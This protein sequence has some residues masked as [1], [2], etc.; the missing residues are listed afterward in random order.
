[1]AKQGHQ[2]SLVVAD[3][4]GDSSIDGVQILDV[5]RSD[6]RLGRIFRSARKVFESAVAINADMYILHDPEL[7][8]YGI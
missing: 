3:A 2:V 8:P 4:H 6:S 7:I 5:G 1:M